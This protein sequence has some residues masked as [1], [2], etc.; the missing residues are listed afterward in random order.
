MPDIE[1]TEYDPTWPTLFKQVRDQVAAGLPDVK[2]EHIG[3]TAVPNAGGRPVIDVMV[4][5]NHWPPSDEDMEALKKA[6]LSYHPTANQPGWMYFRPTESARPHHVF[7]VRYGSPQWDTPIVVRDYFRAHHAEAMAYVELKQRLAIEHNAGRHGYIAGKTAY[8]ED[9]LARV[10]AWNSARLKK[11]ADVIMKRLDLP[12]CLE[13]YGI[14]NLVGSYSTG[15]LVRRDIDVHILAYSSDFYLVINPILRRFLDRKDVHEVRVGDDRASTGLIL[16]IDGYPGQSGTW[17]I[18]I[19]VTHRMERTRFAMDER[20]QRS[21]TPEQ[22]EAIFRIKGDFY[23]RGKLG[24]TTSLRIYGA[25][26]DGGVR[27]P[28]EFEKYVKKIDD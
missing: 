1:I 5:L 10:W 6:G 19:V 27:T 18:D 16:R 4:G 9:I 28:A 22:R 21:L 13:E 3:G 17:D 11:E 26:L 24:G 8:F 2:I 15:L 14:A 7:I 12:D 25:V 20:I 23:R